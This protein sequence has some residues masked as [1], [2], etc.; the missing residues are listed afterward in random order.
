M[1]THSQGCRPANPTAHGHLHRLHQTKNQATPLCM[2][3][4]GWLPWQGKMSGVGEQRLSQV[5]APPL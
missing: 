2:L 3:P 5:L 4:V 1:V